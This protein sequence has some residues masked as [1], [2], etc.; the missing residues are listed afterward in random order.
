MTVITY[1]W[2]VDRYHQAVEAG[3]FDD[4]P[5]ELL[6]GELIE[7][8]PEGIP[9]AS[10]SSDAG[11]YLRELLGKRAKIREGKPITLPNNSEPEPDIAVLE[12]DSAIYRLHHPYQKTFFG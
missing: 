4:Q 12:P 2:T 3:I 5:L 1:K 7:I 10:L 9:H 8:S 11:D 6:N